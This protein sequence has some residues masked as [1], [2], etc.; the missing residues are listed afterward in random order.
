MKVLKLSGF[1]VV[2]T[3]AL[4]IFV[5]VSLI[6]GCNSPTGT[7][8]EISANT[9]K[10][11]TVTTDTAKNKEAGSVNTVSADSLKNLLKG[12][13]LREDGTYT[14][15]IFSLSA[16]GLMD[17][18]YFNPNPIN[19]G[20]SSWMISGANVLLEIILK[21]VNYPGSKYNLFYDRNSD[22]LIG[23]YFQAV[24]GLNYDVKFQRMK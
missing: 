11:K 3:R 20:K 4:V 12:K 9:G 24:Q 8:S 23:N 13:W 14:I 17:A 18:G 19:V 21:D 2:K 16:G 5:I 7:K 10:E 6:F 1:I 22:C 15:E